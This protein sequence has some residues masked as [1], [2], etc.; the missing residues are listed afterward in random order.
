M[1]KTAVDVVNPYWDEVKDS[2]YIDSLYNTPM[3]DRKDLRL[4]EDRHDLVAKYSW[5]ITDPASVEFV[6]KYAKQFVIDPMAGSGYWSR[7]L[8]E[9]GIDVC[10]Y[11]NLSWT[12]HI[13]HQHVVIAKGEA[14]Q[15]VRRFPYHT[16]LLAWPPYSNSI[17]YQT[18]RN[19]RRSLVKEQRVIYIGESDGGCTGDEDMFKEFEDHW[20]VVAEH[21][22]VQ[23]FG[24]H[25]YITVYDRKGK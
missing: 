16:L 5:T 3:V 8:I 11:D 15:V 4:L 9:M 19:Y 21:R 22:P 13:K 10:S 20:E 1:N 24:L 12:N 25:D 23:W 17:G 18:V 6:A 14:P 7:L 2:V